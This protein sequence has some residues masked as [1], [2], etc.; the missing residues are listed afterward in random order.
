[1]TW[2]PCKE[3]VSFAN[4]SMPIGTRSETQ[5]W[6]KIR[7][8]SIS[9]VVLACSSLLI[10][11]SIYDSPPPHTHITC[12]LR[13]YISCGYAIETIQKDK[14][15]ESIKVW[16]TVQCQCEEAL[17]PLHWFLVMTIS[18]PRLIISCHC[19]P[20]NL[21]WVTYTVRDCVPGFVR[22]RSVG[23]V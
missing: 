19:T 17:M 18:Y 7:T 1:M 11:L 20:T 2:L 21:P 12:L 16:R 8:M 22:D 4:L 6:R 15:S 23:D 14:C 9:C 10:S 13:N 5:Q 3:V